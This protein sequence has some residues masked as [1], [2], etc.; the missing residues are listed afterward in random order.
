MTKSLTNRIL[1]KERFF[2]FCMDPGKNL[3]QDLYDFKRISIALSS[4]DDKKNWR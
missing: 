4:I 3:E 2:G 1:L